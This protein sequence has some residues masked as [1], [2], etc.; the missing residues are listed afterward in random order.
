MAD[1]RI[2]RRAFLGG[3]A[4]A[5]AIPTLWPREAS[6]QGGPPP[7]PNVRLVP[8]APPAGSGSRQLLGGWRVAQDFARGAIAIDF[9]RMKLWM[10]GHAQRNEVLEYNLPTMGTGSNVDAWPRVDPVRTIQGWWPK[11]YGYGLAFWQGKLWVSPRVFYDTPPSSG[12]SLSIYAQDGEARNFPGLLRQSFS[13]FV[14]RGPG[15]DPYIGG[16]GSE[17]GQGIS[18][19][20]T[21]ATIAGQSLVSYR[22]LNDPGPNL[23]YWNTR[24]PREP[25]YHATTVTSIADPNPILGADSWMA[26]EPRV[27]GGQLQGRWASDKIFGG[28]L[29]LPEGITYWAWMGTGVLNYSTQWYT[30]SAN[31]GQHDKTYTYRYDPSTFQLLGYEAQPQFDT[32]TATNAITAVLGQELGPDGKVYLA[33]GYQWQSGAYVTDVALKVFG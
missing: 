33:H 29:V 23:E 26:W 25:N 7:P 21:L 12:E 28:G 10:V 16:G 8:T 22:W 14:K 20:P 17:S 32:N 11:G 5:G 31:D 30:F 2:S 15:L 3:V 19:G 27:I 13:G 9:A 1:R 18:A 6:A 4:A 24:P